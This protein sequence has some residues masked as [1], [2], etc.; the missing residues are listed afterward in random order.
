ML[1]DVRQ[2]VIGVA[3][4][5]NCCTV[6]TITCVLGLSDLLNVTELVSWACNGIQR[7][8]LLYYHQSVIPVKTVV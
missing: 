5:H 3:V 8:V 1:Q 2:M 4:Q 6:I 7:R